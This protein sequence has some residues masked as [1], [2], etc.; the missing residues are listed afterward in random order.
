MKEAAV[1][2]LNQTKSRAKKDKSE[3]KFLSVLL[4]MG[5]LSLAGCGKSGPQSRVISSE[6]KTQEELLQYVKENG[7]TAN[8]GGT[9]ASLQAAEKPGVAA[10]GAT[11]EMPDADATE[12]LEVEMVYDPAE[13]SPGDALP[14]LMIDKT[15]G[16][17]YMNDDDFMVVNG[18]RQVRAFIF[19]QTL[20]Q[21]FT[22]TG[23]NV[24]ADE[25]WDGFYNVWTYTARGYYPPFGKYTLWIQATLKD[26]RKIK[27]SVP[28]TINNINNP[29]LKYKPPVDSLP[30]KL[31]GNG[32]PIGALTDDF[33]DTFTLKP[34]GSLVV[35]KESL[36]SVNLEY[37]GTLI[38]WL[39]ENL[40]I[41]SV[42]KDGKKMVA[43]HE[44]QFTEIAD[45]TQPTK[46]TRTGKFSI[47]F[48][49]AGEYRIWIQYLPKNRLN[50]CYLLKT[51]SVRD[52]EVYWKSSSGQEV[53]YLDEEVDACMLQVALNVKVG[54]AP[55]DPVVLSDFNGDHKV[56]FDDFF[57][58][59][60]AF[61]GVKGQPASGQ[62]PAYNPVAD[63]DGDG[64]V[65]FS[66]FFIFAASF[67]KSY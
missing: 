1:L 60:A 51:P 58:F 12:D 26:G 22:M 56:A 38:P 20:Q 44:S 14:F 32:T 34:E 29:F 33:M 57:V 27:G 63:L 19:D 66:D 17:Y 11:K 55:T 62:Q 41:F 13:V 64:S 10:A 54:D 53:K 59:A 7:I 43:T 9:P 47:N 36:F 49:E 2:S 24:V 46:I 50:E 45:P 39:G 67:G 65:A 6:P 28:F 61:G 25:Q 21:F 3:M 5:A 31:V 30:E 16:K 40:R 15:R 37:T 52:G 4:V 8:I 35:K 48:P 18:R 42:S 23:D